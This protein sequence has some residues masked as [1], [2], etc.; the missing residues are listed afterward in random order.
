MFKQISYNPE[1][2]VIGV[3]NGVYQLEFKEKELKE[4]SNYKEIEETLLATDINTF[5]KTQNKISDLKIENLKG[6]LLKKA[7]LTD[8]VVFTPFFFGYKYIVSQNFVD[9]LEEEK[10]S[11][12]EYHLREIKII[13]KDAVRYYLF[14]V[15]MIPIIEINFSKSLVYNRDEALLDEKKQFL[16]INDYK[17]YRKSMDE[18]PFKDFEMICLN[19][20]YESNS[21]INCQGATELFFAE[22]LIERLK[23]KNIT[24]LIVPNRQIHLIFD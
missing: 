3:S 12:N 17:E 13:D 5:L 22:S 9:C 20:K 14:F 8:I 7:K 6:R 2:K 11:K 16:D 4:N 18:D 15:P 19:K 24:N 23:A 10:V 1:S 21:I